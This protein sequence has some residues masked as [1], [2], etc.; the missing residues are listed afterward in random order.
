MKI[1]SNHPAVAQVLAAH[2]IGEAKRRDPA[3]N[4]SISIVEEFGKC[5]DTLSAS[6]LE[7]IE[8][9]LKLPELVIHYLDQVIGTLGFLATEKIRS[10]IKY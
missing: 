3:F 8:T 10:S 7:Q 6:Q 9:I 2:L 5:T 4:A 1:F